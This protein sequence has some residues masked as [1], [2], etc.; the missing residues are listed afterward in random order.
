MLPAF[1]ASEAK[2][3]GLLGQSY[4]QKPFEAPLARPD[5]TGGNEEIVSNLFFS[6]AFTR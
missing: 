5:R 1:C 6:K 3:L 4:T 2:Q